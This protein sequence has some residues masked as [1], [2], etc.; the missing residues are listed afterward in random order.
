MLANFISAYNYTIKAFQDGKKKKLK[1]GQ[2][3]VSKNHKFIQCKYDIIHKSTEC[4]N[5][6]IKV[7]D[8]D[9]GQS[10]ISIEK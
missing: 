2:E 8:M 4:L 1:A 7:M 9:I 5:I 3:M 10:K 6:S